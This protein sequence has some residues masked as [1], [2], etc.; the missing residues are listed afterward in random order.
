MLNSKP[1]SGAPSAPQS[2][3]APFISRFGFG[4]LSLTCRFFFQR[5]A[6]QYI[7]IAEY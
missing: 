1:G 2:I 6:S 7:L 4:S 5:K 3:L